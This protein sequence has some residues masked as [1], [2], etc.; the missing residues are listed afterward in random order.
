MEK[1]ED[2]EPALAFEVGAI[3][4]SLLTLLRTVTHELMAL[5]SILCFFIVSVYLS[6]V[7]PVRMA[8]GQRGQVIFFDLDA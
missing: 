6:D 4:E 1:H 7:E 8:C 5:V 2:F 3:M